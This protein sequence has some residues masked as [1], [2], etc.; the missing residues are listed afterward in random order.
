M[1]KKKQKNGSIA[2]DV[3]SSNQKI[4]KTDGKS[5]VIYK[6]N[7]KMSIVVAI[8]SV[9]IYAIISRGSISQG[10]K[11]NKQNSKKDAFLHWFVINGGT[12]HSVIINDD[13]AVDV[14]IKEFQSYGGWGLALP[15]PSN[16]ERQQM[17]DEV[18]QLDDEQQCSVDISASS[19]P[20][21][22]HLDPLFTVPS[23]IIISVSSILETYAYPKSPKYLPNFYPQ[24]NNILNKAFPH[25]TGLAKYG[26]ELAEQDVVIAMYLMVEQCQHHHT[27]L[28]NNE[29]DSYWG[30]YLDVLPQYTISRLDTFN[31]DA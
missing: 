20:I 30:R 25:G 26:M 4:D 21:I 7:T 28:Y 11:N 22:R 10:M 14:T 18:C 23:S 29:E 17:M 15:L 24:V 13:T 9:I 27:H 19:T 12:F 31:D 1:A 2:S 6:Q 16:T 5:A 8:L 3:V